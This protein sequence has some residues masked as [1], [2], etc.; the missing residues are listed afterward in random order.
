[1]SETTISQ[2]PTGPSTFTYFPRLSPELQGEI[3]DAALPTPNI[4]PLAH[5]YAVRQQP[6]HAKSR[7]SLQKNGAHKWAYSLTY[8]GP[9]DAFEAQPADA[10]AY[11]QY[12]G[13]WDACSASRE[14]ILRCWTRQRGSKSSGDDTT[15]TLSVATISGPGIKERV[16]VTRPDMDLFVFHIAE[17]RAITPSD[18][19]LKGHFDYANMAMDFQA[20]FEP[21]SMSLGCFYSIVHLLGRPGCVFTAQRVRRMFPRL[22][23]FWFV[24]GSLQPHAGLSYDQLARGCKV[25]VADG[26]RYIEVEADDVGS[27]EGCRWFSTSDRTAHKF[28]QSSSSD[29]AVQ[30]QPDD[31]DKPVEKPKVLACLPY[32]P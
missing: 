15:H 9:L 21:N 26:L 22:R 18:A 24:D 23:Q 32:T 2:Q 7:L 29:R 8:V 6:V 5:F 19:L 12:A 1:M 30:N 28:I 31:G 27:R 17:Q 16:V 3:W 14:A 20:I 10:S 4:E 13:L 25:F 11:L